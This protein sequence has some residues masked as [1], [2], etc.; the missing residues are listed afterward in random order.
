MRA[1][2]WLLCFVVIITTS[3]TALAESKFEHQ[4]GVELRG[5]RSLYLNMK[6]PNDYVK[7]FPW[8]PGFAGTEVDKSTGAFGG[9]VSVLYKSKPYF[10]WHVGLNVLATDSAT[11]KAVSGNQVQEA[12]VLTQ[13]VELFFTANYYWNITPRLN[14]EFGAG[15]SFYLASMDREKPS[16]VN[17]VTQFYGAH[18]R[19]FG[20][21]GTA[22]LELF[23]TKGMSLKAG[24]G[25]RAAHVG[26]FKYFEE[27]LTPEG[28]TQIGRIAYWDGPS[29]STS[30]NTFEADFSGPFAEVGLRFYFEPK[31]D[32][33]HGELRGE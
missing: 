28:T 15:P 13:A 16:N 32:W 20:F 27:S 29:G 12:R 33:G 31:G 9:G 30:F 14:L 21:V 25:F 4:Y 11:A 7:A 19:A 23:L 2:M 22:G 26:R 3:L 8:S 5:S 10:A 1:L 6:D 18:G 24:G 17:S